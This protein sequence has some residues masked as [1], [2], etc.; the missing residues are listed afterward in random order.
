MQ[1]GS[2]PS[3]SSDPRARVGFFPAF[4]NLSETGRMIHIAKAAARRDAEP[5]FFSHGGQFESL[6]RDAGILGRHRSTILRELARNRGRNG[7]YRPR[8]VCALLE[9]KWS[10]GQVAGYL[11][12]HRL[13]EISHESRVREIGLRRSAR[14]V[15]GSPVPV[16]KHG[17][18]R[19]ARRQDV[20]CAFP[21]ALPERGRRPSS[22]RSS[23]GGARIPCKSC[24][25]CC[26]RFR[27]A[28]RTATAATEGTRSAH[29]PTTRHPPRAGAPPHPST[30]A[31]WGPF[32]MIPQG[33]IRYTVPSKDTIYS[34]PRAS[35]PNDATLLIVPNSAV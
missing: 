6:A 35:S 28:A 8:R 25:T 26:T 5:L 9:E 27:G 21:D 34:S 31:W 19:V 29:Q 12:R 23:P 1:M 11:R 22:K 24:N 7:A 4:F 16:G 13:L 17:S 2:T 10:P 3:R 32:L 20:E 33:T 14:S 18:C 30:E 15:L